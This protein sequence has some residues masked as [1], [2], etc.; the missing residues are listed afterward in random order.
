[1]NIKKLILKGLYGGG[2]GMAC[3][4]V[5][6]GL[7]VL[8]VITAALP[9]NGWVWGAVVGIILSGVLDQLR[10][11]V[12][13]SF[14]RRVHGAIEMGLEG[15]EAQAELQPIPGMPHTLELTRD[16]GATTKVLRTSRYMVTNVS[17]NLAEHANGIA[18][19]AANIKKCITEQVQ[20]TKQVSELVSGLQKVFAQAIVSANDTVDVASKSEAEGNSG[21][22]TMTQAM[23]NISS[24]SRSVDQAGKMIV[25]LGEDNEAMSGI[26]NVIKSIAEQTNLLALN[27]AIEAARAG[28][29]GRGFAV[30]ADEVRTLAGKTQ[31]HAAQ[32]ETIIDKLMEDVGGASVAVQGAVSLASESDK[33]MEAVVVSYS[34]IVGFMLEVNDLGKELAAVTTHE[35]TSIED[36]FGML[37]KINSLGES[38]ASN[39]LMMEAASAE[40]SK[41]GQQLDILINPSTQKEVNTQSSVELF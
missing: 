15:G 8:G 2:L 16:I 28:E 27:A 21:K 40:L 37:G 5:A 13:E 29:Q 26:I 41:L 20:L 22:L 36:I 25:K 34:E 17:G 1:M 6:V 12:I 31:Q 38:N 18:N 35:K 33:T 14:T 7:L 30:V 24:L 4:L 19:S 9:N 23:S 10:R 32:I 3:S 39:L 11:R